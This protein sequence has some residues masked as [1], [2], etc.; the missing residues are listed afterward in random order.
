MGGEKGSHLEGRWRD[1]FNAS[2]DTK[3][4]A[5][6][7]VILSTQSASWR[8]SGGPPDEAAYALP[9]PTWRPSQRQPLRVRR[10]V[11][12]PQLSGREVRFEVAAHRR[13]LR[14]WFS[15]W[16]GDPS[17]LSTTP[18][19]L[20]AQTKPKRVYEPREPFRTKAQT[21]NAA[22]HC[23]G[24]IVSPAGR[25]SGICTGRGRVG[26]LQAARAHDIVGDIVG[27]I[28]ADIVGRKDRSRPSDKKV[29]EC[30]AC[31]RRASPMAPWL[32]TSAS[33]KTP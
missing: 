17:T 16:P 22:I 5:R 33:R 26:G 18:A 11:T 1:L 14:A 32:A 28:V 24:V 8:W 21:V 27:D 12:A 20:R 10:N 30:S 23:K 29:R 9:F 7:S 13:T 2:F 15:G 3:V 6:V 25:Q 4:F 19:L 31:T